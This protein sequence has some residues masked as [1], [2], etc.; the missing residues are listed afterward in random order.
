[1]SKRSPVPEEGGVDLPG[2]YDSETVDAP[3]FLPGDGVEEESPLFPPAREGRLVDPE[4]WRMAEAKLV[5]DLSELTFDAGRLTER[6]R[7]SGTG[8]VQRLALEEAAAL[9]WWTGDRVG[10]DLLALWQ[11]Y[12]IGASEEDGEG[13]IRTAWAARR[14]MMAAT[15]VG[16]Q[17]T[18]GDLLGEAGRGD[19]ILA[20]DVAMALDGV[21][22]LSPVVRGC[23][24]FHLWRSLDERPD[25]LRGLEA[26][27]LGARLSAGQGGLAFLPL[28][29][30][31]FGALTASGAAEVRLA[32]WIGGAHRAVFAALMALD[33]LAAWR[34]RADAETA[35]LSGRTPGQLIAVLAA[36]P[37]LGA[38]QA[39]FETGAS[40]AAVLRN[41]DILEARGLVRE[42]T[43]QGRF[44]VWAARM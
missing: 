27:V 22:G 41:F 9:S 17:A 21:S 31:G 19:A 14:L 32:A 28:A 26:A 23:A 42:V 33:R 35:D 13:L 18:V 2:V 44:R 7:V 8:A 10:A 1:M 3:W 4:T 40:R 11:S 30:T 5:S 25:H 34:A 37:M 20:E 6:L 16:V 24:A 15:A 39:E 38:A 36:H 29:L 12:R 43:G